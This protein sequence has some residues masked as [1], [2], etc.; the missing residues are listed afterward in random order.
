MMVTYRV[1][2]VEDDDAALIKAQGYVDGLA[3]EI[4]DGARKVAFIQSIE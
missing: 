1:Y 4:W 2:R 3:A